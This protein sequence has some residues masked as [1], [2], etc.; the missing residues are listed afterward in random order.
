LADSYIGS[1]DHAAHART[2]RAVRMAVY[3]ASG[4][5]VGFVASFHHAMHPNLAVYATTILIDSHKRV[6]VVMVTRNSPTGRFFLR[7][8]IDGALVDLVLMLNSDI[9]TDRV[10][11]LPDFPVCVHDHLAVLHRRVSYEEFNGGQLDAGLLVG[12][13]RADVATPLRTALQECGLLAIFAGCTNN[14]TPYELRG[15][16][17]RPCPP[18]LLDGDPLDD[19]LGPTSWSLVEEVD[20]V[21]RAAA[22]VAMMQET[23]VLARRSDDLGKEA[24]RLR[25][26]W[27]WARETFPGHERRP[28]EPARCPLCLV[29]TCLAT[30]CFDHHEFCILCLQGAINRHW[31]ALRAAA[32]DDPPALAGLVFET[33][34]NVCCPSG[35]CAQV[36]SLQ[37]LFVLANES[38]Q[39]RALEDAITCLDDNMK[40]FRAK[41]CAPLDV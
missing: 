26:F 12:V 1:L 22:S 19:L 28:C 39:F 17:S 8:A 18:G 35:T 5:I 13:L 34:P 37:T 3:N 10:L 15:L 41:R 9:A 7:M 29:G 16:A 30:K 36:L 27:T 25:L 11:L 4:R 14:T 2:A 24:H 38:G 33:V 21:A 32:L 6:L 20:D 40:L 31:R 23:D